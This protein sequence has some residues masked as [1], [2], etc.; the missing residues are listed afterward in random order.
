[1]C[2]WRLCLVSLLYHLICVCC[3]CPIKMPS[4]L[5]S[6]LYFLLN[7]LSDFQN[8]AKFFVASFSVVG[9]H[10]TMS[11]F[12]FL[13]QSILFC[14]LVHV[15]FFLVDDVCVLSFKK[16]ANNSKRTH[17]VREREEEFYLIIFGAHACV[18]YESDLI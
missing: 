17:T 14:R 1:M 3:V 5:H 13:Q 18:R 6:E 16:K 8:S 10:G 2:H 4:S 7:A 15:V 9:M 12:F 11:N